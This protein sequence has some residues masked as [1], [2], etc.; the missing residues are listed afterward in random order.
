M[1]PHLPKLSTLLSGLS[2]GISLHPKVIIVHS[3]SQPSNRTGWDKEWVSWEDFI[4]AGKAAKLGR[5]SNGEIEWR[6]QTFDWPIWILF[7]SGT[8]GEHAFPR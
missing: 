6:R 8:T 2:Q 4:D 5:D 3:V 1:H 7:S